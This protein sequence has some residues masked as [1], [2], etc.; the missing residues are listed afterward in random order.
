MSYKIFA[1]FG[2]IMLTE[3]RKYNIMIF[4]K[5]KMLKLIFFMKILLFDNRKELQ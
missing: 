1:K 3:I 5:K 4:L 2:I